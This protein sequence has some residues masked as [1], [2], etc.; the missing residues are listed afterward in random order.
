MPVPTARRAQRPPPR[1]RAPPV[2]RVDR[3]TPG[4]ARQDRAGRAA[5]ARASAQQQAQAAPAPMLVLAEVRAVAPGPAPALED[6]IVVTPAMPAAAAVTRAIPAAAAVTAAILVA[7]AVMVVMVG[8]AAVKAADP[9]P[10]KFTKRE[11]S[12]AAKS[13]ARRHYRECIHS[14]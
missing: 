5:V 12:T 9:A 10:L 1:Q 2:L 3:A 14:D 7:A 11:S 4:P 8:G 6:A 13:P